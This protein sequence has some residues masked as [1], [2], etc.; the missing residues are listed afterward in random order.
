M[1]VKLA[2]Y[3]PSARDLVANWHVIDA[4]GEVLGR[5]ATRVAW[6]LMGKHKPGYVPN[7]L[8]GDF[9]V[10]TNATSIKVTG[11]KLEKKSYVR[12]TGYPG[13]RKEVS[14]KKMMEHHPERVLERAV[15]GML[16]KTKLG[17]RMFSRLKVCAGNEHPYGSQVVGS[18][19]L[20]ERLDAG[21]TSSEKAPQRR[22]NRSSSGT[23][24]RL[25]GKTRP[26]V[27]TTN[28]SKVKKSES[29]ASVVSSGAGTA[30]P[31]AS[32]VGTKALDK[33][34]KLSR[35]KRSKQAKVITPDA[36]TGAVESD[37]D[38]QLAAQEQIAAPVGET[39]ESTQDKKPV[40]RRSTTAKKRSGTTKQ[41]RTTKSK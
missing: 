32:E 24:A 41:S 10:I 22:R 38:E 16:P 26:K 39:S 11:D 40:Q 20:K 27:S 31:E 34:S 1:T 2:K 6:L 12:H 35:P 37:N 36:S 30:Q 28:N 3:N 29:A 4:S 21:A 9:V 13:N 17:A 19:R 25:A 23:G 15:R 5:L 33:G 8:A 18:Q 7:L 14:F